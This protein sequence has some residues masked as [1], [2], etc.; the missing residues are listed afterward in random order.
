MVDYDQALTI[1]GWA[2]T[3]LGPRDDFNDV[4]FQGPTGTI[5]DDVMDLF[6]PFTCDRSNFTD[7]M[8]QCG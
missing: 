1:E 4:S 8:L 5:Y 7:N 6:V 2:A 3:I